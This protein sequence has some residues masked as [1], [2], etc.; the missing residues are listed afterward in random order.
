VSI[1]VTQPASAFSQVKILGQVKTPQALAFRQGMTV[2]DAVLAAGGLTEFAAGNRAKLI[3]T[4]NG[5]QK[6]YRLKLNKLV[7]GGDMSQNLALKAGDAL[8]IPE[9]RF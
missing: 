6:E 5:K 7:D 3:R 4:E 2:L 9:S 8:L 1:I